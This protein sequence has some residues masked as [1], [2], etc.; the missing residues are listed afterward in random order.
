MNSKHITVG[1]GNHTVHAALVLNG[2]TS[3]LCGAGD[4]HA[5]Q[6]RNRSSQVAYTDKPITCKRCLKMLG[7]AEQAK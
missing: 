1:T 7:Q 6:I 2:Y 4:R 5:G 3:G